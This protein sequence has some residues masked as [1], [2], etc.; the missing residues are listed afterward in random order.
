MVIVFRLSKLIRDVE[1]TQSVLI[2][3]V[4]LGR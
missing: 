3:E 1:S 4:T 2:E